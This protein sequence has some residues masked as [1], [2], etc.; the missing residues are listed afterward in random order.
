MSFLKDSEV[1]AAENLLRTY[2]RFLRNYKA[3]L[4]LRI[5]STADNDEKLFVLK[6]GG[7]TERVSVFELLESDNKILNKILLVF[8][9]LGNEAKK[10]NRESKKITEKL[11]IIEDEINSSDNTRLTPEEATNNAIVKFSYALEDLLNMKFLIQNSIFLSVNVIHQFSALFTM[12]KYFQITPS[13]CFPSNLDDV[14]MLF[15]NLMIFDAVFENSDYKTYLQLYGELISSQEGQMDDNVLRNLQNTLH[16][17]HLLLDGN[18][19][20]IA[21]DNLLTLKSKIKPKSLKRLENFIL[22][23]I[24]NLINAI[25]MYDQNICELTETDEIIKLN[26]FIVIYQNLFGNFDPKNFRFSKEIN[27]KFCVITVYNI[28][29]NGNVFLKK[30]VSSLFKSNLDVSKIQQNF[31]NQKVQTIS[32]DATVMYA[33]QVKLFNLEVSH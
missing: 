23:Y 1:Q 16:E 11:I 8:F 22:V 31:M 32:K 25:S 5:S 13:S 20:Q 7:D 6:F 14:G 10:L 3:N 18:I 30:N 33:S 21:I 28:L 9:H 27:N 19:F 2:G 12:E 4:R 24:K 29:W 15:R 26:I 17:L